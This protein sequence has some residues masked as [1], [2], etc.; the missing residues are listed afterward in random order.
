MKFVVKVLN[1]QYY[2]ELY[3]VVGVFPR[4]AIHFFSQ[5]LGT[6]ISFTRYFWFSTI[7]FPNAWSLEWMSRSKS[8]IFSITAN[9]TKWLEFS[10][11]CHTLLFPEFR[12]R[13]PFYK[14]WFSTIFFPN[15]WNHLFLHPFFF[16]VNVLF[17][18][19]LIWRP[20]SR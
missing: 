11:I 18:A 19:V 8:W 2:C 20:Y 15:A 6:K 3:K 17:R 10:M 16:L 4:F 1:F 13:D 5:N 14:M 7:V 12:H 9:C